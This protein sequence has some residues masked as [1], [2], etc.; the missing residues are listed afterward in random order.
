M[1]NSTRL[2]WPRP[3]RLIRAT[4]AAVSGSRA[5]PAATGT[6]NGLSALNGRSAEPVAPSGTGDE[7]GGS[8]GST[9]GDAAADPPAGSDPDPDPDP[10]TVADAAVVAD[11][12]AVAAVAADGDGPS[13]GPGGGAEQATTAPAVSS[14]VTARMAEHLIGHPPG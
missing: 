4:I 3:A 9:D 14:S 1:P 10:G 6:L 2:A 12:V 8:S 7:P 13:A 5:A 11:A